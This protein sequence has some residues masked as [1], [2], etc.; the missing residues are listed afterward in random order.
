S[1]VF[2]VYFFFSSRRRHT[3]F[4]RDWSS[5][6]CSSDLLC[7]VVDADDSSF[8]DSVVAELKGLLEGID[9]SVVVTG[10]RRQAGDYLA[11]TGYG[12]RSEERREGKSVEVGGR[13]SDDREKVR[14]KGGERE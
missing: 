9:V 11:E 3:R 5:D 7:I 4:S 8:V 12:V 13:C 2:C 14:G 6:V 1:R 10:A